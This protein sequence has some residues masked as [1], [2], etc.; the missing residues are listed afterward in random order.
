M[1]I[2]SLL[3]IDQV[4]QIFEETNEIDACIDNIVDLII[5]ASVKM[6][7]KEVSEIMFDVLAREKFDIAIGLLVY[8]W[9]MRNNVPDIDLMLAF[10]EYH[11]RDDDQIQQS[12]DFLRR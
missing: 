4:F 1:R 11:A 9:P 2:K 7:Y 3:T 6:N 5:L 12:I 8:I 10:I